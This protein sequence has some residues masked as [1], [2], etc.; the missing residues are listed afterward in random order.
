MRHRDYDEDDS[1]NR[2]LPFLLGLA[3]GAGLTALLTPRSGPALRQSLR[4]A[5]GRKRDQ[6]R[7]AVE[8][9]KAAAE[10]ARADLRQRLAE[11]KAASR[12]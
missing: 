3:V 5:I 1:P 8:E 9:G 11:T 10:E 7:Y 12:R 2:L 4:N 6:V